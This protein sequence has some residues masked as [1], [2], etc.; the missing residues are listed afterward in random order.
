MID[1][2]N[3]GTSAIETEHAEMI[4]RYFRREIGRL[5]Q[6][7]EHWAANGKPLAVHHRVVKADNYF[8]VVALFERH[9]RFGQNVFDIIRTYLE[10]QDIKAPGRWPPDP[11]LDRYRDPAFVA[12]LAKGEEPPADQV[13]VP[14]TWRCPKCKFVLHQFNLNAND[15]S[16]T[17]RDEPGDKCPNDG[18]PLWR[19]TWREDAME[20]AE[21][22]AEQVQRAVKAEAELKRLTGASQ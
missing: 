8:Q 14:G 17:T 20:L 19:V 18:S 16:V 12:A 10:T 9:G 1:R 6:Q 2:Q 22:C 11:A 4:A 5:M 15:G 3:D 13:F 7:A 21:R